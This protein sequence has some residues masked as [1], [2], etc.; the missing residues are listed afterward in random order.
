MHS[1][2]ERRSRRTYRENAEE[3]RGT[4]WRRRL[5]WHKTMNFVEHLDSRH[6]TVTAYVVRLQCYLKCRS[7]SMAGDRVSVSFL[8]FM[9]CGKYS[10]SVPT[11]LGWTS[12]CKHGDMRAPGVD[13]VLRSRPNTSIRGKGHEV[14]RMLL[15]LF[16]GLT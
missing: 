12:G 2:V 1:L 14:H 4:Y 8:A 15:I 11:K 3:T 9:M 10:D 16:R 13:M 7:S 5:A 6:K